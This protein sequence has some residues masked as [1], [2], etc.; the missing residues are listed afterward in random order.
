MVVGALFILGNILSLLLRLL[1]IGIMAASA[2]ADGRSSP[3]AF[4][5]GGLGIVATLVGIAV[6]A[7]II[8]GALKM[9]KLQ[10]YNL[11][12]TAAIL[13]MVPC[14]ACCII[15]LGAGIWSLVVLMKPE[16]KAAFT[17]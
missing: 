2:A 6:G 13:A 14:S 1:G 9:R 10:N 8:F 3:F 4:L 12:M 15:G 7:V 5:S 11:A 16:V 17:A